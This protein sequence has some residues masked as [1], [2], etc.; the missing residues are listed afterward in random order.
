VSRL[1]PANLVDELGPVDIY[2]FD[3]V[4][5]GRFPPGT[6][7]LDAG[8]G[9]GRNLVFFLRN[10]Y[11][12]AGVD[13]SS[14]AVSATKQRAR[15]LLPASMVESTFLDDAFRVEAVEDLSFPDASFD[16][17]IASALLHFARDEAHFR[18]MIAELWRVLAPRGFLF[19]RLATTI[20]IEDRVERIEGRRF[21]LPDGTDRFL[22]DQKMLEG[23]EA[24]LGARPL[25]PL[26]TV[27]VA[28]LRAMTTW[29]VEKSAAG[30]QRG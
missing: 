23:F 22:A 25:E 19:T 1:T 24:E 21:H 18:G 10:G 14:G 6:R 4:L 5:K 12:V 28:H 27:N 15:E 26:K 7:V 2:L 3:Q 20:G 11:P 29:V 8:C 16:V 17:V 13:R 9:G 30:G